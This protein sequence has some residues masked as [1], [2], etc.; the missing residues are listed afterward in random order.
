MQLQDKTIKRFQEEILSWYEKNQRELPWQGFHFSRFT[1][2]KIFAT[3]KTDLDEYKI[4][5]TEW[6]VT[7][8]TPSGEELSCYQYSA[9]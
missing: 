3:I 6:P 5:D 1:A 4:T 2:D 7:L 9:D 8:K